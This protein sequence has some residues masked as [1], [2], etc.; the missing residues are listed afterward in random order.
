VPLLHAAVSMTAVS[1]I[2]RLFFIS[3]PTLE[4]NKRWR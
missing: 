2:V 1:A 4:I 3:S